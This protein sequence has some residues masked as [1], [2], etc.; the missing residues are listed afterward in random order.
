MRIDARYHDGSTRLRA[1]IDHPMETGT[2]YDD[3]GVRI[4]PLYIQSLVIRY[5]EEIV[6]D[7][8]LSSA[9]SRNPYFS[10]EFTGGNIGDEVV[11]EWIDSADNQSTKTVVIA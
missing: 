7:A 11:F 1:L 9:I 3:Q 4:P 8:R 10:I 6:V 2:R 5:R